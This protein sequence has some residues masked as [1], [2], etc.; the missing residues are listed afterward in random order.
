MKRSVR[1]VRALFVLDAAVV[2][3]AVAVAAWFAVDLLLRMRSGASLELFGAAWAAALLAV[4]G[5]VRL[6]RR[7]MAAGTSE[8]TRSYSFVPYAMLGVVLTILL[9]I[10]PPNLPT[11]ARVTV[12]GLFTIVLLVMVRQIVAFGAADTLVRRLDATLLTVRRQEE[13]MRLMVEHSSDVTSLIDAE[14]RMTYLTPAT[15]RCLGYDPDGM[16]GMRVVS[17]IHP[18][19]L[20]AILPTYSG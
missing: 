4:L 17:L 1:L 13:R 3:I 15:E 18:D 12:G 9:L 14:G 16:L 11:V 10:L 19:D 20:P 5:G 2:L 6:R 7:R 8:A